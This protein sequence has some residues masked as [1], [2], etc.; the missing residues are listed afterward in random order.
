VADPR[1]ATVDR[2]A[3]GFAAA[4]VVVSLALHVSGWLGTGF[5]F[6]VNFVLFVACFIVWGR[7]VTRM[8]AVFGP[9]FG[10]AGVWQA[11][12]SRAPRWAMRLQQ[13]LIY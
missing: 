10:K 8:Q 12:S 7:A 11:V 3:T 9:S 4:G 5:G 1:T 13:P 6:E 2:I